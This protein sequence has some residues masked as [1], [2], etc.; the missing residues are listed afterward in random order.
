M[1]KVLVNFEGG[2]ADVQETTAVADATTA[3]EAAAVDA[4]NKPQRTDEVLHLVPGPAPSL[5]FV[6]QTKRD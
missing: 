3:L 5:H 2:G 4:R 1:E 6:N